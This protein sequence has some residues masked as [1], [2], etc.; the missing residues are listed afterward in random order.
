MLKKLLLLVGALACFALSAHAQIG[1]INNPAI[2]ILTAQDSGTCSAANGSLVQQLPTNAG[3]TTARPVTALPKP[4][5][6]ATGTAM[7]LSLVY[8]AH[9]MRYSRHKW[10]R[11]LWWAPQ[12]AQIALNVGFAAHNSVLLSRR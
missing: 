2:A 6:Y 11:K 3:T 12:I 1:T 8:L 9:G 4:A 7:A 10:E 5:Y